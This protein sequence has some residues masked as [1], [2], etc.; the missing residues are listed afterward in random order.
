M[1]KNLFLKVGKAWGAHIN[2]SSY[3]FEGKSFA[4]FPANNWG[5]FDPL[6]PPS[7]GTDAVSLAPGLVSWN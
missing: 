2:T 7:D 5:T 6:F 1:L 3:P 4:S